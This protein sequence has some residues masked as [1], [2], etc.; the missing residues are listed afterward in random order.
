MY[1]MGFGWIFFIVL[2]GIVIYFFTQQGG[3]EKS[4]KSAQD[5]L[6]ERYAKGEIEEQEYKDKSKHLRQE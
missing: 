5:I 3:N 2:I 6:D 1:G 4:E